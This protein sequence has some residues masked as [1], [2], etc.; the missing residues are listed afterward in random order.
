MSRREL[1]LILTTAQYNALADAVAV[2]SAE[3]ETGMA[4]DRRAAGRAKARVNGWDKIR[5]AWRCA[6]G[7]AYLR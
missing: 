4:L 7:P 2:R 1:T 6:A 5:R 3:D